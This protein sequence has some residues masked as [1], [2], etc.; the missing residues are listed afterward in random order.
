MALIDKVV[1]ILKEQSPNKL[2]SP[3]IA[4]IFA[5]KFPEYVNELKQKSNKSDKEILK[6]ISD[7]I[8]GQK[9]KLVQDGEGKIV[10]IDDF[11]P[12]KWYYTDNIHISTLIT[13]NSSINQKSSQQSIL[14]DFFHANK[15]F[16]GSFI[17]K[18][19]CLQDQGDN[20]GNKW[21]FPDVVAV[22]ILSTHWHDEVKEFA[23]YGSGVKTRLW[24]FEVKKLINRSNV[25][26]T[27]FQAVSNSGWANFGYLV[28]RD[29]TG[30]D[31]LR[32]LRMLA[33]LHGIGFILLDAEQPQESEILIPASERFNMNWEMIN[34]LTSENKDF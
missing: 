6:Q 2:T 29:L 31:T 28:A 9:L 32:E 18:E 13:T 25:R 17:F 23:K 26:E 34:R 20:S 22:E 8:T 10:Q 11:R 12:F 27:Y 21:L 19:L 3:E 16:I 14:R 15:D 24:S 4:K 30:E 33:E 1:E 7:S 5:E